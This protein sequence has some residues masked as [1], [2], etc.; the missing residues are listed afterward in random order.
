MDFAD[1]LIVH[2]QVKDNITVFCRCHKTGISD[3]IVKFKQ[4]CEEK[5]KYVLSP[6]HFFYLNAELLFL[7]NAIKFSHSNLTTLLG[8]L[9][10]LR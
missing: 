4:L 8:S 3:D 7:Y 10:T 1:L 5:P 2:N 6:L 9:M